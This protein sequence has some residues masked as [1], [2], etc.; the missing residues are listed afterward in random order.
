MKL[1]GPYLT[2]L[3]VLSIISAPA[4]A[5]RKIKVDYK[6]IA[7]DL[8]K[9]AVTNEEKAKAIFEHLCQTIAYDVEGKISTPEECY[10]Y[11]KGIC[12]AYAELFAELCKAV[13]V[14]TVYVSGVTKSVFYNAQLAVSNSTHG[15]LIVEGDNKEH[16]FVDPTW[17]AGVVDNGTFIKRPDMAWFKVDPE[18]MIFSHLPLNEK[19][20][21]LA[22][23][24][25]E[26]EF[27]SMPDLHPR[28]KSFGFDGKEILAGF[29]DKSITSMPDVSNHPAHIGVMKIARVPLTKTLEV[30]QT[31]SFTIHK[32]KDKKYA[33]VHNN[34]IY[35][36]WEEEGDRLTMSYTPNAA[37]RLYLA[38]QDLGEDNYYEVLS[39]LVPAPAK[40]VLDKLIAID[41][42]YSP[43]IQ[44]MPNY[45]A[46]L[47]A[48]GFN[49]RKILDGIQ[50]GQLKSLPQSFSHRFTGIKVVDVPCAG[51]LQVGTEYRFLFELPGH[52]ES[53]LVVNDEFDEDWSTVGETMRERIFTPQ[54]S[55]TVTVNIRR[56]GEEKYYGILRYTIDEPSEE[57]WGIL[58]RDNPYLDKELR[59]LKGFTPHLQTLRVDGK[60]LVRG[61]KDGSITELPE[62]E[63]H[64]QFPVKVV[65]VPLNGLLMHGTAY[66]FSLVLPGAGVPT[67]EFNGSS[68]KRN[69]N[70]N[71]G[72]WEITFTPDTE[73]LLKIGIVD[74]DSQMVYNT[75]LY[76][77]VKPFKTRAMV[78]SECFA[79]LVKQKDLVIA[80]VGEDGLP[81]LSRVQLLKHGE[82]MLYFAI[83]PGQDMYWQL[84]ARPQTEL[85]GIL[86]N[87]CMRISGS[88]SFDVDERLAQDIHKEYETM[89]KPLGD[90]D[91]LKFFM[92]KIGE[93]EYTVTDAAAK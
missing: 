63:Y 71:D 42:Y 14:K 3:L 66:T 91:K 25:T 28:Y 59:N 58:A 10:T 26:A 31:Y 5:Q 56:K 36:D 93:A 19:Q 79:F 87:E 57:Q 70:K 40:D 21:M 89:K 62:A 54:Q 80:T 46:R 7:R 88:V 24:L 85:M 38:C 41:P 49:G 84:R 15:Y 35:T 83:S 78:L 2:I 12:Q 47:K 55:G 27:L 45:H 76:N 1:T 90:F 92:V 64:K 73:G 86:A 52:L 6:T 74:Q 51:N 44:Q 65:E 48:L 20:Q 9:D 67:L 81:K 23:P 61:M 13:K 75:L 43:E 39:Y 4:F 72:V 30:G 11:K 33:L 69:W 60:E 82:E 22:K 29:R 8:T 17:G 37:G 18:W 50:A 16:F 53:A 68:Y 32:I 77:V 34:T